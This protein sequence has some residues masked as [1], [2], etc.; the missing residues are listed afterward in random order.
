[1]YH[2]EPQTTCPLALNVVVARIHTPDFV[3]DKSFQFFRSYNIPCKYERENVSCLALFLSVRVAMPKKIDSPSV[4]Q[5]VNPNHLHSTAGCICVVPGK[6]TLWRQWPAVWQSI[7]QGCTGPNLVGTSVILQN[8]SYS[9]RQERILKSPKEF[10]Q[11][12]SIPKRFHMLQYGLFHFRG[13][14]R[15][16]NH[17]R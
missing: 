9:S 4:L 11:K 3:W 17:R 8:R 15:S 1:M 2:R 6:V 16:I 14:Y 10:L 7:Y 5:E 13:W 12:D